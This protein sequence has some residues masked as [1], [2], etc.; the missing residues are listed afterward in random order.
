MVARAL[1]QHARIHP[2]IDY[3]EDQFGIINTVG[4]NH[5]EK[6]S[7]REMQQ[8]MMVL[9][10][11]VT[12]SS[13]D[14]ISLNEA[15][16]NSSGRRSLVKDLTRRRDYKN[17]S[18]TESSD[19]EDSVVYDG[20]DEDSEN[21]CEQLDQQVG[22]DRKEAPESDSGTER[23]KPTISNVAPAIPNSVRRSSRITS[24][25]KRYSKDFLT[26]SVNAKRNGMHATNST[27]TDEESI[28]ED[29]NHEDSLEML[30]NKVAS[31]TLFEAQRDVA[32][33]GIYGFQTP[34][35]RG[36]M[37]ALALASSETRTPRSPRCSVTLFGNVP[38]TP[39]HV[40]RRNKKE[41][42]K[43]LQASMRE[44]FSASE[45][46]Y[47]PSDEDDEDDSVS[48]EAEEDEIATPSSEDE[49][50]PERP[51]K[52]RKSAVGSNIA[53]LTPTVPVPAV[54][55]S[56]SAATGR[57]TRSTRGASSK[58]TSDLQYIVESDN[59]FTTFSGAKSVTSDHTLDRL[60]TP[61]LPQDV[62]LRLLQET[63]ASSRHTSAIQDMLAEY[64]QQFVRWLF[65]LNEGFS[66]LL[67]GVGSKRSLLQTF[68]LKLLA[69]RPVLVVNGFFP[70]LT[71]KDVLDAVANDLLD[72]QLQTS[73]HHEAI[74]E[75]EYE[76]SLQP[77]L[78]V[79]LLVHNLDGIAMRGDRM[80]TTM[81]RLASIPNV[82]LV[83]TID[84]IN[85]PLL[86]DAYKLS[87]YNFCWWDVT[88][89]LPYSVETA[90]ENSLLVQS[91]GALTLSSMNSVFASLTTNAR[92]IFMVIVKYQLANS[93]PA[94]P[95]Y[96]GMQ[97]KD[98]YWA[99]REA[100]LVSS[101]IALRAQ[102]TEFTDHKLLRI[103][104][105]LDG[106]EYLNIPIEH[107][108]LKRFVD[109]TAKSS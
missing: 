82:H 39:L 26:E 47:N 8:P 4:S 61:R 65:L 107:G 108:L 50:A 81:C 98:L 19:D 89:M 62:L 34:K 58:A 90:F 15:I 87:L 44:D 43:A 10:S 104:R 77:D 17:D 84:H 32:G 76:L 33:A 93:G 48:D 14:E 22:G 106:S 80:Q 102:L 97:F 24:P 51:Q 79:F 69:N 72:L 96:A 40:R 63:N 36:S 20:T 103:K 28:S 95:Q 21:R 11:D 64:E 75:I 56:Q 73:V 31:T 55:Q 25:N 18:A 46:D 91:G 27:S 83:A 105:S 68:H 88:T 57:S 100:F 41:L 16:S 67:Y 2:M 45:S 54:L 59:Y 5:S 70:A 92:G 3:P 38:T 7:K 85:A 74:D 35:K 1:V 29:G 6:K 49:T 37:S 86:W 23:K 101:D 42:S 109:E 71:V 13:I 12:D 60:S 94:N 9:D 53:P 78:H 52:G 66:V 30:N 99:C